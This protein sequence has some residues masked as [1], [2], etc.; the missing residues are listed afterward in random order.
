MSSHTTISSD[1]LAP[2]ISASMASTLTDVRVDENHRDVPLNAG[3]LTVLAASR[4]TCIRLRASVLRP[5][6]PSS[7]NT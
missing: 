7:N 1:K 3:M 5:R 4:F 6:T 2:L